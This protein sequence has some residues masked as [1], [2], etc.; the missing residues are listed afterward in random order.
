MCCRRE[1]PQ[2]AAVTVIAHSGQHEYAVSRRCSRSQPRLRQDVEHNRGADPNA[3][4]SID[5]GPG[6]MVECRFHHIFLNGL[7]RDQ[8]AGIMVKPQ[9]IAFRVRFSLPPPEER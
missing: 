8:R 9:G 4:A 6:R 3:S 2:A 1:R 5:R 7:C